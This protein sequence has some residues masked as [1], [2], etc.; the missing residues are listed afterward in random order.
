MSRNEAEHKI[1]SLLSELIEESLAIAQPC[2]LMSEHISFSNTEMAIK[3]EKVDLSKFDKYYLL[4][5]GKASQTMSKWLLDNFPLYF[6]RIIIVSPNECTEHFESLPNLSF[7]KAGHPTPNNESL[8]AAEY[9]LKFLRNLSSDDLCFV[10][11]SGGGSS[12]FESP[13]F[14]V[15]LEDYQSLIR[16][17]L[18]SGASIHEINTIRKH[19]S[20]VKGGK[21]A[22]ETKARIITVII[23]D[24]IG[25]NP[26]IIASGPTAPDSSTW[27]DCKDILTKYNLQ[28]QLPE[29]IASTIKKGLNSDIEDTP[30][31]LSLFSHVSNFVIGDNYFVSSKLENKI[32][33]NHCVKI[34][35]HSLSGESSERG[36]ELAITSIKHFTDERVSCKSP[37]CF[38]LFSGE[39]TVTIKTPAGL[40][41]RNQEL[42][43]SFALEITD[44]YPIYLASFGTDGID[45]TS[46]AAGAL[47]G[48]FTIS[49]D[50]RK[51]KAITALSTHDS[52]SFFKEN[53]GEI[54]T[55]HTGTNLM[56]I[57]IICLRF[58]RE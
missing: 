5:F 24:V 33:N 18:S 23:S 51:Q 9:S 53:G 22:L 31:N 27:N 35:T 3:E 13:D 4:A 8:E 29:S 1:V 16:L 32:S 40:G 49:D 6:S 43:L 39:T 56:D 45:G 38:L 37:Y 46:L 55:D 20:K 25:N 21:L 19:F 57:G 50:V 10:L 30:I 7:F 42:A 48:P 14:N 41:G 52:N 58:D 11:I 15:S 54:I 44:K 47:V 12:L 36:K 17:L 34:L 26:S 2:N 28:T